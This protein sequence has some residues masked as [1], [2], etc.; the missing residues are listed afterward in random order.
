MQNMMKPKP[1]WLRKKISLRGNQ[2]LESLFMSTHVN[3]VCQEAMCPNISECFSKKQATFLILGTLCTRACSF[4]AVNKGKPIAVDRSEPQNIAQTVKQLGLR[5]VVITSV[6]RDDLKD[7]GAEHFCQTVDAIKAMD[8]SIVVELLIPDMSENGD[9]LRQVAR[10]GAEIVGHNLE[11]VPRLYGVRG[12]SE[13]NRSLRVLHMLATMNPAIATKSGIMLGLGERDEEVAA[14]MKELL[15]VGCKYLSIGQYLAPSS[16]HAEV[17]EYVH[18]ERFDAL[19]ELGMRMG[20]AHIKS[21]PYVRSSYMAHE[22]L[23]ER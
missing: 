2:E 15:H 14:L 19:R 1:E 9:A 23:E 3:T 18:P 5:H 20:F 13:Y 21:S 4:C 12:G 8:N 22:Y 7:G 11:T 6:T 10:S 17:V 16:R